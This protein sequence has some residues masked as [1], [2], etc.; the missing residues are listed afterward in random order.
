MK[1]INNLSVDQKGFFNKT[2]KF[3]KSEK[4]L[5]S[6]SILA[7]SA[8]GRTVDPDA[9][10]AGL[11]PTAYDDIL[12][13]SNEIDSIT[14]L[15]GND[16]IYGFGGNDQILAGDGDDT[17][18]GGDGDD[19]IDPGA[20]SDSVYGDKGNDRILLSSGSDIE[21]GGEGIDTIIFN[22]TQS[23]L[24]I[25]I[26]LN[27]GKYHYTQQIAS[28]KKNA[29][30]YRKYRKHCSRRRYRTRHS[31]QKYDFHCKWQRYNSL[32]RWR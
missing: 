15:A 21:D 13:G 18:Y 4:L 26:D 17:I 6:L 27:S 28:A 25:T 20:G 10:G 8:C 31:R 23:S 29:V 9:S 11:V 12:R 32:E 7:L 22:S 19:Y 2:R 3:K 1:S 24:P 16:T 30:F 5:S 14:G